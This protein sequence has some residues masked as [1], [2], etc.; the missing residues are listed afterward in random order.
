MYLGSNYTKLSIVKMTTPTTIILGG[1]IIG[2]STAYY[3]SLSPRTPPSSI[4]LVEASALFSSASGYAA[5]F[6]A[7][8]GW[9]GP[10]TASLAELSFRLHKEL[11]DEFDGHRQWGYSPSTGTSL[12]SSRR[13]DEGG[14][15][16]DWLMEGG[17]REQAAGG[18]RTG[19]TEGPKWLTQREDESLEVIFGEQQEAQVDPRRLCEFLLKKIQE[20]GVVLHQP[21]QALSISCDMRDE[22]A[23]VRIAEE[24]G[25]EVDSESLRS[26]ATW[27]QANLC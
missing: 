17:S 15:G 23:S 9:F 24:R 20:R 27:G 3:L 10:A 22:L 11:A 4:H 2:L 6:L 7:N 5:G 19:V 8:K 16:E 1:G 26:L 12:K 18:I 25:E 14:R 21:A 13:G